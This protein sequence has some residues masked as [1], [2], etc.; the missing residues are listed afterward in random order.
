M[1]FNPKIKVLIVD[2]MSA[3]RKIL[4]NMLKKISCESVEHAENG[5]VAWEMIQ[6]AHDEG[7]PFELIISDWNMPKLSGV[8]LLE[9]VRKDERCKDVPFIMISSE[10]Q[11]ENIEQAL[12]AG[13]SGYVIKP[14]TIDGLQQTLFKAF[15]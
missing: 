9:L 5:E 11:F 10:S 3:T 14:F 6:K 13:V 15:S 1:S 12:R 2:D 8:E 7:A 4:T